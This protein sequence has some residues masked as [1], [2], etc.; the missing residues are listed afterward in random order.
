ME[1]LVK[2]VMK[3]VVEEE[4]IAEEATVAVEVEALKNQLW[5]Y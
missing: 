4:E 1:A 3:A 2:A 5:V